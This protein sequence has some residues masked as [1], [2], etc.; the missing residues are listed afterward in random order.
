MQRELHAPADRRMAVEPELDEAR[1]IRILLR[2][3]RQ[4]DERAGHR[5]VVARELERKDVR[6]MLLPSREAAAHRRQKE[7]DHRNDDEEPRPRCGIAGTTNAPAR[8]AG[9]V[10]LLAE[11][12][13]DQPDGEAEREPFPD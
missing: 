11:E 3:L 9:F 6:L 5:H 12:E 7:S 13:D 8:E 4:L 10:K 1:R 2:V